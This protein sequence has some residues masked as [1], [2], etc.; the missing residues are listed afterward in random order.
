[1]SRTRSGTQSRTQQKRT[2]ARF[3]SGIGQLSL[4]E[5]ALCPLDV[6]RTGSSGFTHECHYGFTSTE[7]QARTARVHVHCPEGLS[8]ADEFYLWG[9]LGLA[10]GQPEPSA[11]F[12]ATPY[13]CLQQ[14]GV[15]QGK[16][17]GGKTYHLFREAL[18]R[19]AAVRYQNDQFY[20]PLRQE[21]R[22]VSFGFLSYSLP[23]Q[24][25][26]NRAWRIYWDPLF[27]EYCQAL[28]GAL[29]F[30]LETYREL[31]YA[32]R[33]LYLL[34]Q[35]VFWRHATSPRFSLRQ[36]AVQTLGFSDTLPAEKLRLRIKRCARQLAERQIIEL[37]AGGPAKLFTRRSR[38]SEYVQFRRHPR[39]TRRQ[40]QRSVAPA[41]PQA[42]LLSAIGFDTQASSWILKRHTPQQVQLWCD[43]TLAAIEHKG[44]GFFQRNAQ[45]FFLDNLKHARDGRRTPP[46]WFIALRREEEQPRLPRTPQTSV[47]AA[48]R[49][50]QRA[51][52]AGDPTALLEQL[53]DCL[54][55][56]GQSPESAR[57][58]AQQLVSVSRTDLS[59]STSS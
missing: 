23:L 13:Y 54:Q 34:L 2:A 10:L 39:F 33:R 59:R 45:A 31:S 6:R 57:Q 32:A 37:P 50:L 49:P 1:M 26:S 48:P 38:G 16:A 43:V 41:S 44:P 28:G 14:L 56:A 7:G 55:S 21:N 24:I 11:D 25:D 3:R 19:L 51:L 35:K 42:E 22:Q 52:P 8:P 40:Q 47:A 12:H 30:D 46:D 27:F 29:R 53:S 18:R 58:Q 15:L 4:L 17:R 5:H 20:D 36:L 9:L